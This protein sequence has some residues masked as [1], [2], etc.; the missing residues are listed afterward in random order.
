MTISK[1]NNE[2]Y[3]DITPYKALSNIAKSDYAVF[4]P[5]VYIC[6]PFSGDE[7]GNAKKA[8]KYCR[9]ALEQK[10]IPIAPHLFFPQFMDDG[11]ERELAMRM[12]LVLLTKCSELWVFGS[13]V[14]PGMETEIAKAEKRSMKIRY[15]T[16]A[17]EEI[18]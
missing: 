12:N 5:L 9:F 8:R 14:S 17:L 4:R 7:Q 10:T 16:E 18:L 6:S 15:F 1:F 2:G 11:E 3:P 13:T